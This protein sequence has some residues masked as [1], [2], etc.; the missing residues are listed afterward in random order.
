MIYFTDEDTVQVF[1]AQA[2]EA[3]SDVLRQYR[4]AHQA[5]WW[6][7]DSGFYKGRDDYRAKQHWRTVKSLT[8][9]ANAQGKAEGV[10]TWAMYRV[11]F[12]D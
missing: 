2:D 6:L 10:D 12:G 4:N 7:I 8:K 11:M 5:Y 9:R 3:L 1:K